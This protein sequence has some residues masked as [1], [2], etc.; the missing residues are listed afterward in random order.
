MKKAVF[1]I[2]FGLLTI[3]VFS[4]QSQMLFQDYIYTSDG[5]FFGTM[6]YEGKNKGQEYADH[7]NS[8]DH[9]VYTTRV[10]N[11]RWEAVRNMMNRYR[12]SAGDTYSFSLSFV[13]RG[14]SRSVDSWR[15]IV[16]FTS[17]TNYTWWAF[18]DNTGEVWR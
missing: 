12:H 6:Y 5:T 15:I 7:T 3:A 18:Y 10:S 1:I 4:Q 11:G 14:S 9:W 2:V 13:P 16:Q 17:S 8:F